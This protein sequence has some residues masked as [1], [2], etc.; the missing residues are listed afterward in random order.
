MRN[1]LWLFWTT[2]SK[3]LWEKTSKEAAH[4]STTAI[5]NFAS[6]RIALGTLTVITLPLG[7]NRTLPLM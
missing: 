1:A 3:S 7:V 4:T 5:T 6:A 2:H